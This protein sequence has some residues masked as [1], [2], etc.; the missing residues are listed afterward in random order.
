MQDITK[1]L[2]LMVN[3]QRQ[4]EEQRHTEELQ[5]AELLQ[6][7]EE[8]QHRERENRGRQRE[9]DNKLSL[10]SSRSCFTSFENTLHRR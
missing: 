7:E 6:A 8:C 10:P 1:L 2:G 3:S 4:A 9:E 5:Q